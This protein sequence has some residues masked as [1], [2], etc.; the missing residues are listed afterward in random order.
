MTIGANV[1]SRHISLWLVL[2]A[3][4]SVCPAVATAAPSG[5]APRAPSVAA[6][7]A[8]VRAAWSAGIAVA[9]DLSTLSESLSAAIA[10]SSRNM[11]P[12]AH[13]LTEI[14]SSTR[15]A[16]SILLRS[17][18]KVTIN[19]RAVPALL[20]GASPSKLFSLQAL[21]AAERPQLERLAAQARKLR[22][23]VVTSP[24]QI[25]T[26]TVTT[27]LG[28]SAKEPIARVPASVTSLGATSRNATSQI[29]ATASQVDGLLQSGATAL[30]DASQQ[31]LVAAEATAPDQLQSDLAQASA[32]LNTAKINIARS[33]LS[34]LLAMGPVLNVVGAPAIAFWNS[35]AGSISTIAHLA[36]AG[37]TLL[38]IS[39]IDGIVTAP[40]ALALAPCGIVSSGIAALADELNPQNDAQ[41]REELVGL[42]LF[43]VA[44]AV[45]P[46]LTDLK[47]TAEVD[48][49]TSGLNDSLQALLGQPSLAEAAA[50]AQS[51]LRDYSGL[52]ALVVATA[53]ARGILDALN[54]VLAQGN[55]LHQLQDT[56]S[57]VGN[58]AGGT[59]AAAIASTMRALMSAIP[60]L[61][62]V[63]VSAPSLGQATSLPPQGGLSSVG[64]CT[65]FVASGGSPRIPGLR[66]VS[67]TQNSNGYACVVAVLPSPKPRLYATGVWGVTVSL[68]SPLLLHGT[69]YSAGIGVVCQTDTS[70]SPDSGNTNEL[71]LVATTSGRLTAIVGIDSRSHNLG[72]VASDQMEVMVLIG[73]RVVAAQRL[74]GLGSEANVNVNVARGQTITFAVSNVKSGPFGGVNMPGQIDIVNLRVG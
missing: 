52:D 23:D 25:S 65:V 17:I 18:P 41:K 40:A 15:S 63:S 14:Q 20:S 7:R 19:L 49:A 71:A 35:N 56:V 48:G 26:T 2:F 44:T 43:G 21:L 36:D 46:S 31:V 70:S 10:A 1:K 58:G 38:Q 74:S 8:S 33:A 57:I 62:L 50:A 6:W 5:A 32:L 45:L 34:G 55:T 30:A 61:S 16:Q 37:C 39:L 68:S 13:F 54:I 60:I 72:F 73:G 27:S 47:V 51:A 69:S 53:D 9:P 28:A 64:Q 4:S 42:D 67:V 22:T 24:V 29:A 59:L 12:S 3:I 66:P 11:S